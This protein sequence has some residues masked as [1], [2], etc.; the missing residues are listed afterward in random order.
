MKKVIR[1]FWLICLIAV[2][3]HPLSAFAFEKTESGIVTVSNLP[4]F[5]DEEF[6]NVPV[7]IEI[8]SKEWCKYC[9]QLENSMIDAIYSVYSKEQVAIR[10]LDAEHSKVEKYFA[11]YQDTFDMPED[12]KGKVPTIVINGKYMKVGYNKKLNKEI[13]EGIGQLL[14]GE[15]LS[16][17]NNIFILKEEFKGKTDNLIYQYKEEGTS[18]NSN[19]NRRENTKQI[20]AEE[21]I[22]SNA[23]ADNITFFAIYGL[24]DSIDNP[25]FAYILAILLFFIEY[26]KRKGLTFSVMYVLGMIGANIIVK[27][28]NT[29]L[30]T[31]R[32]P[33]LIVLSLLF[34][35][36]S[37]SI[38]WD[39]VFSTL[40]KNS[41]T[42]VK[43]KRKAV[44]N[45]MQ[46]FLNSK[47]S[48][49]FAFIF[50]F[51]I[52]LFTTP[53]DIDYAAVIFLDERF[54]IA[55]KFI[56]II[57]N[58]ICTSVLSIFLSLI[59]QGGKKMAQDLIEP[60]K[61]YNLLYFGAVFYIILMFAL[62]NYVF[63]IS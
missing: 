38:F 48:Y 30:Y 35:Y 21:Q 6:L 62:I 1:L 2:F 12:I 50:G 54:N 33:I 25:I 59:V 45:M 55:M 44:L 10:I 18:T 39:I 60:L 19:N 16:A 58:G 26:E 31:Y 9:Q 51:A 46:K 63:R 47:I 5:T 40:N 15:E 22:K 3:V 7:R 53:Y 29:G 37:L 34:A 4:N 61:K 23:F 27:I 24:Y 28:Y 17:L 32:H 20:S 52:Y 13:I 14:N 43:Y 36:I 56:L 8:F 49:I 41:N 57:I 42:K 11:K